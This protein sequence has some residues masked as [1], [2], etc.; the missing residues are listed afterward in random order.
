MDPS[1]IVKVLV[2]LQD[3]EAAAKYV[4]HVVLA[5]VVPPE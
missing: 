5:D 3:K 2:P 1:W 4:F